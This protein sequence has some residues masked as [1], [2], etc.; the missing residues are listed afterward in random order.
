MLHSQI[1]NGKSADWYSNLRIFLKITSVKFGGF[2]K[3]S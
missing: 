3:K 2:A 1:K